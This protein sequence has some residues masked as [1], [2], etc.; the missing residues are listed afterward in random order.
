MPSV[1]DGL[2]RQSLQPD[3]VIG[4]DNQSLDSSTDLLKHYGATVLDWPHPYHHSRVLNFATG[5][6]P[7]DL[8]L[9]LSSHTT[10]CA[11][12]T[13]ARM[14]EAMADENTAC[15]SGKWDDDPF[16]S[17]AVTWAEL[18]ANG[19]KFVSIYSNSFGMFRRSL[20]LQT[21]FD[22]SIAG[23]EDYAWALEWVKRGYVC[24]RMAFPFRYERTGTE[25]HG[26]LATVSFQLAA[27][28]RL[29]AIW[30]GPRGTMAGLVRCALDSIK[31]GQCDPDMRLHR[32]RLMAWLTWRWNR[33]VHEG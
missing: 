25:R 30:L 17:D 13:L 24:R 2:A 3:L 15:V 29:R 6:C 5:Q 14:A 18:A 8:V 16:Y 22:E 1:L 27:R 28:H 11:P 33:N 23:M 20:W 4:V 19:M 31:T 26:F 9:A 32:E 10:F 12:D 7:A 21:P